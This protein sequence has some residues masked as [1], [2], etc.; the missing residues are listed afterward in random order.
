VNVLGQTR[1]KR[2]KR[3][4]VESDWARPNALLGRWGDGETGRRGD[5]KAESTRLLVKR[6]LLEF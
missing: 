3:E 2:Y 4:Q 5:G 1:K 6:R